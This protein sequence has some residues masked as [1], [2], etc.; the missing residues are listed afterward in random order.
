[1]SPLVSL[2]IFLISQAL[3]LGTGHEAIWDTSTMASAE[4]MWKPALE[5]FEL[6]GLETDLEPI[7]TKKRKLGFVF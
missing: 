2:S 4:D 7:Q 5:L 6:S 1:M 3:G